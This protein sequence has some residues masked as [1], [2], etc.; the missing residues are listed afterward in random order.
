MQARP[1]D[2]G[3]SAHGGEERKMMRLGMNRKG[4]GTTEYIVILGI[5]V[6]I[7]MLVV[8]GRLQGKLQTG[9][10]NIGTKVAAATQ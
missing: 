3:G 2:V 4:Q 1:Y 10:D 8:Y 6:G 7:A 5:V 9:V